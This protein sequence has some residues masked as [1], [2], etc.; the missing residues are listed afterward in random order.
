VRGRLPLEGI[1]DGAVVV[2]QGR[3]IVLEFE[4]VAVVEV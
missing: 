2:G 1:V 3:G 4:P